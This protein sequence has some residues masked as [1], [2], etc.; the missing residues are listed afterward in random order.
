MRRV[1]LLVG[2]SKFG[3]E[4]GIADLRYPPSDVEAL[5]SILSDPEI[6]RF[7]RVVPIV[8]GTRR[9][10][11]TA[12][13][14]VLDEERG[15]ILL[16][17]YSGHGKVS[18]GGRLFLAASD[19]TN[20][21]LGSTGVSW[22]SILEMKDDFGYARCCAVLDC[23]Y[24]GLGASH[25]KGGSADEHLKTFAEGKGV[26]FLAASNATAVAREDEALEHGA[27]TA[28]IVD[29]LKSGLADMDNDGRVTGPDLF[30]WCRD[31]ASKRK[32]HLPVQV[33][34]TEGDD[35]VIAFSRQRLSTAAVSSAREKLKLLWEHQFLPGDELNT[36]RQF[37]SQPAVPIPPPGSL[38]A[39]FIAYVEQTID[40]DEFWRRRRGSATERPATAISQNQ[41]TSTR[42][43]NLGQVPVATSEGEPPKA[44]HR[45]QRAPPGEE[46]PTEETIST[47][48]SMGSVAD[49]RKDR[50]WKRWFK[51]GGMAAL[52]IALAWWM[53][54]VGSPP[55]PPPEINIRDLTVKATYRSDLYVFKDR[56]EC[57]R[58]STRLPPSDNGYLAQLELV[59]EKKSDPFAYCSLYTD[60]IALWPRWLGPIPPQDGSLGR[61]QVQGG[62]FGSSEDSEWIGYTSLSFNF[63]RGRIEKSSRTF[64]AFLKRL[65]IK[66]WL[67]CGE[68]R[69][70]EFERE[71]PAPRTT[72]R[73]AR[74]KVDA[75][76]I[77]F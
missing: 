49:I 46:T 3:P 50:D 27:L 74:V 16:F 36:L 72:T 61:G 9:Q 59:A 63:E 17:Y 21:L 54:G 8:E 1:A 14:A 13:N 66:V 75:W 55:P 5:A 53:F 37:F 57:A 39:D 42:Q 34:R 33:N 22:A 12:W 64:E 4:S 40:W 15:G 10:I 2:N 51:A 30:R 23:C 77:R 32:T 67:V 35:L 69:I 41:T 31:F 44:S 48:P 71:I 11:L 43:G 65:S 58:F 18:D 56:E 47:P 29:G 19:T 70:P 28:A 20:R 7:D 73:Y 68:H 76:Q 62:D 26:F 52:L 38:P 60:A 25:V 24:A 6:G 45:A